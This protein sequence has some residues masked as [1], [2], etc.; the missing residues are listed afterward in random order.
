[1]GSRSRSHAKIGGVNQI[2]FWM[3]FIFSLPE[4]KERGFPLE[5][6]VYGRANRLCALDYRLHCE[7]KRHIIHVWVRLCLSI[8]WDWSG[9]V[10]SDMISGRMQSYFTGLSQFERVFCFLSR[11]FMHHILHV[12]WR[13]HASRLR[14][15]R[16]ITLLAIVCLVITSKECF[17]LAVLMSWTER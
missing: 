4:N 3:D 7:Y 17:E 14:S 11:S 8:E 6:K 12:F 5:S 9:S 13:Y 1:M 15:Y 2:C 10:K 16:F